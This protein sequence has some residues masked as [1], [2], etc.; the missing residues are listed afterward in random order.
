MKQKVYMFLKKFIQDMLE[1]LYKN[2]QHFKG[3]LLNMSIIYFLNIR[4]LGQSNT[5]ELLLYV[6]VFTNFFVL[7]L[8]LHWFDCL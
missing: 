6:V 8:L 3:V 2:K 4:F 7:S 1:E 5:L